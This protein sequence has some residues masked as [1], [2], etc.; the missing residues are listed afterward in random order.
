MTQKAFD[1][2]DSSGE[3]RRPP[4]RSLDLRRL[5]VTGYLWEH[6]GSTQTVLAARE[7]VVRVPIAVFVLTACSVP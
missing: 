3:Q 2:R 1:A 4:W 6:R 7:F 5:R